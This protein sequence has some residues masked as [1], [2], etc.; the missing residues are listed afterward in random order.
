MTLPPR[1]QEAIDAYLKLLVQ[2]N[3]QAEIIEER[4]KALELF[5]KH[6]KNKLQKRDIYSNAIEKLLINHEPDTQYRYKQI[7]REFYGFWMGDIKAIAFF[8]KH[9][10]F[11]LEPSQ[12]K[13]NPLNLQEM[14]KT[15]VTMQLDESE[16]Y[17]LI[18]YQNAL[19]DDGESAE[20]VQS[21]LKLAK[22]ILLRL[23]DAPVMNPHSYRIAVD[24]IL[25]LFTIEENKAYF[26]DVVRAFYPCWL[27][28]Q[29][30]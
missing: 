1:E 28:E 26:L 20:A 13:P 4:K 12:W 14:V 5:A 25:P 23:R 11:D 7:A 8:T 2:K 30:D 9:Y 29:M 17:A 27:A 22:I 10:G 19:N 3:A 6:L 18:G 24:L 16:K 21:A 15:V